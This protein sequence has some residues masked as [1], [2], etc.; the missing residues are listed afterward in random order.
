[1]I[2][3]TIDNK[4]YEFEEKELTY[5]NAKII[6]EN[7]AKENLKLMKKVLDGADVK[8]TL[9]YGTLLG[10]I[11]EK[12]FIKHDIDIDIIGFNEEE[13]VR[14]IPKLAEVGLMLVRLEKKQAT[15]SFMKD[16]VYI[17]IYIKKE[18]KGVINLFY[19]NLLGRPFPKKFLKEFTEI[20][21]IEENFSIPKNHEGLLEYWYGK[22]WRIPIAN[23][24]SNDAAKITRYL[25][26]ILPKKIFKKIKSRL[27]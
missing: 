5:E 19:V 3:L 1:M 22:D 8:F 17:D 14:C 27:T 24:P 18:Y 26:K 13:V 16:D 6:N 20:K 10:A 21:F 7:I 11:R 12:G 9:G 4:E 25:K 15:Y 2:K 23:K